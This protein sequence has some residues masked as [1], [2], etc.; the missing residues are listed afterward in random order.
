MDALIVGYARV[1]TS[2]SEQRSALHVQ[3]TRLEAE[4]CDLILQDVE[5]GT[6]P[7]RDQYQQLRRLVEAG[8]VAEVVATALTRLGRD[9]AESDAFVRLCDQQGV[10]C[11]SL[12][13]GLLTMET[14]EDLL[15]TRLRGS[16]S[17]GE[18]M[19]IRQR[20]VAGLEQ[21]RRLGKPMRRPCWGYRL[22]QDRMALE[23]DPEQF[24]RA[25]E[26]IRVLRA[27]DWRMIPT[28]REH[29]EL[30]PFR[31]CR[32]LRAW[33]LNPTLRGG[34]GYR[35]VKNHQFQ[36]ILWDRHPALLTHADFA[37]FERALE[38]N[39]R[40]WGVNVA[41][42]PRLLTSLC[43]CDEC[44]CRL[45]Y[46]P[47]RRIPGLRCKGDGCSQLYR[48]TREE[49][50]VPFIIDALAAGAAERLA[51]MVEQGESA[52]IVELRQQIKRLELLHDPELAPV[53]QAKAIRLESLIRQPAT[54]QELIRRLADRKLFDL[55]TAE[56]LRAIFQQTVEAVTI[57]KQVPVAI[58]LRL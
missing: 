49:R 20:V 18:S 47:D 40:H 23:P 55:A 56:Q 12:A 24:P 37:E 29:P 17:Q 27:N 21:G 30:T 52:E 35:Q 9:A 14:P 54:D 38:R 2:S 57:S 19:R 50:I 58:R 13:E 26:L 36:E 6:N 1:S 41:T 48:S 5:T 16:L 31:S 53:I 8:R 10:R 15:L 4:G 45:C 3:I 42:R 11:R 32:G 43:V 39:R 46:I 51:A 33:M 44:G 28:L 34:V 22:R 7:L 25:Q